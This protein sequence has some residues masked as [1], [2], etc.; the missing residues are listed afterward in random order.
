MGKEI[1][2]Q[3]PV[4]S[5]DGKLSHEPCVVPLAFDVSEVSDGYHTFGELYDHRFLLFCAMS[6]LGDDDGPALYCWKSKTHWIDGR[7]EPV[8]PG[9]FIAGIDLR[10]N[11]R[12]QMIT[13]HLPLEYWDLF[14]G[15]ER[16]G[17]PPHD[18]HTSADVISRLKEW[19]KS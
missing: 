8:W 5:E 15:I 1:T 7:L 3:I 16:D 18:G 10:T 12:P 17:A 14:G 11:K 13:Y 2:L 6:K 19:L 4:V 9:W